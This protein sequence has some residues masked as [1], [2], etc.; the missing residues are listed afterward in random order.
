MSK[1]GNEPAYPFTQAQQVKLPDGTWDQNTE[2]GEPGVTKREYFAGRGAPSLPY[3]TDE[4]L[5]SHF[6]NNCETVLE[7]LR[8]YDSF[9][10]CRDVRYADA[11]LA[12][13]ENDPN[14]ES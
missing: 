8:A 12:E 5:W 13:L 14:N 9:L 6:R 3:I 7:A 4:E 10:V 2:Y 11:L 1:L